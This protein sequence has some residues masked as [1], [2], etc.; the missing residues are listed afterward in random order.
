VT[1]VLEDGGPGLSEYCDFHWLTAADGS[2]ATSGAS[3]RRRSDPR[4]T[5]QSFAAFKDLNLLAFQPATS[6]RLDEAAQKIGD[7]LSLRCKANSRRFALLADLV[8]S[9]P[10]IGSGAWCL[11]L[12]IALRPTKYYSWKGRCAIYPFNRKA[13]NTN[14]NGFQHPTNSVL[15][16][17]AHFESFEKRERHFPSDSRRRFFGRHS[18]GK[19]DCS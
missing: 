9:D 4:P 5:T 12:Y 1:S 8:L 14:G 11:T 16:D 17:V 18:N 13:L 10:D 6:P 2:S 15:R 7:T 3:R 19:H